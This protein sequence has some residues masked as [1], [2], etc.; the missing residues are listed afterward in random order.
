VAF[1]IGT[2]FA[3]LSAASCGRATTRFSYAGCC[4]SSK[5]AEHRDVARWR[6]GH[7]FTHDPHYCNSRSTFSP[8]NAATLDVQKPAVISGQCLARE[9]L[10]IEAVNMQCSRVLC[11]ASCIR[12]RRLPGPSHQTLHESATSLRSRTLC[13]RTTCSRS[14]PATS[15]VS[16]R[17]CVLE[18]LRANSLFWNRIRPVDAHIAGQQGPIHSVQ[19]VHVGSVE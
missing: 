11:T 10:K 19:R 6:L 1:C 15:R 12:L 8:M 14:E 13:R 7:T 17:R 16:I 3:K 5:F 2:S 4:T 18:A 9:M